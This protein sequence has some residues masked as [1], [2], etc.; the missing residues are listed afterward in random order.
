MS[1]PPTSAVVEE[2]ATER[3]SNE[4]ADWGN[5]ECCCFEAEVEEVNVE[6]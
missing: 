3:E 4:L 1:Q 5:L 2:G 6:E